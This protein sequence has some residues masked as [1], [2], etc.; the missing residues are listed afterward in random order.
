MEKDEVAVNE[1][2]KHAKKVKKAKKPAA[3]K[4]KKAK[5]PAITKETH[6]LQSG[7]QLIYQE[8]WPPK[9][10][11]LRKPPDHLSHHHPKGAHRRHPRPHSGQHSVSIPRCSSRQLRPRLRTRECPATDDFSTPADRYQARLK[12]LPRSQ[13]LSTR[14]QQNRLR[15]VNHTAKKLAAKKPAAQKT[16]KPA[17]KK[18]EDPLQRSQQPRNQKRRPPKNQKLSKPPDPKGKG[19]MF[20][21]FKHL[22]NIF[23]NTNKGIIHPIMT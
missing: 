5:K 16:K 3:K 17:F 9:I 19:E 4:A 7:Q 6:P 10:Q 2:Y 18:E 23:T 22:F 14:S 11:Q 1:S 21:Y 20:K 12:R 13:Q 8:R 15:R